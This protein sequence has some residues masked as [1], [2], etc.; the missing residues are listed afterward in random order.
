[1][2]N[3][4]PNICLYARYSSDLQNTHS[5]PDQLHLCQDYAKKEGW[6]ISNSYAD[7]AISGTS[8]MRPGLQA[9]MQA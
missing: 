9:M 5:I 2:T 4:H 6:L 7:A 1:M 3:T 8:L